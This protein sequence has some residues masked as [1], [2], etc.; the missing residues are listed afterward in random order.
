M[1]AVLKNQY[2]HKERKIV[3]RFRSITFRAFFYF[4]T[5]LSC[6]VWAP[7]LYIPGVPRRWHV[8]FQT[9][10]S[11]SVGFWLRLIQGL[12]MDVRGGQHISKGP[13][14][15]AMKHQ[16]MLDTFIM[17]SILDDPSFIMKEELLNIPLYGRLCA[18]VGN[19]AIDRDMGMTSM[20]KM[21]TR[22]RK[23]VEDGRPVI[24][25]PEGSRASPGARHPYLPGIFGIY[26]YLKVPVVPIAVNTGLFWPR[27]GK[28]RQG[29]FTIE[30]L[31]AIAPGL[32]KGAFMGQLEEAI[33]TA[34]QDLLVI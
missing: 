21:L 24:I 25:F 5:I 18:K 1:E 13:V 28:T 3:L 27:D 30:F 16:S 17:H 33:E 32:Q 9:G 14:I 34:C 4:W 6:L 19:I 31:P 2:N 26:K 8:A 15:Y 20:K 23:E 22:S 10:W 7:L 29:T 12:K 11:R